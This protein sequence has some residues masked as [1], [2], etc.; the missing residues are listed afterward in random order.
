MT[1]RAHHSRRGRSKLSA[2][3]TPR[4]LIQ[5]LTQVL[6]RLTTRRR[7][8]DAVRARAEALLAYLSDVPIAILVANNRARYVDV[9]QQAVA[10]TGYT[11]AE[12][13]SMGLMDLTPNPQAAMSR[14]LWRAFLRRGRMAGLYALRRKDGSVVAAQYVAIANV[15]PSVHVSA[16]VPVDTT[17]PPARTKA[18]PKRR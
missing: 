9:N 10:L 18:R 15:L 13:T 4:Q 6:G 17:F 7:P 2:A 11:R 5:Q 16:L 12:L 8:E 14:R 3:Q 1:S